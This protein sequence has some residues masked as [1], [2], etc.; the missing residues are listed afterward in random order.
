MAKM[1]MEQDRKMKEAE[2]KRFRM[3]SGFVILALVAV[4]AIVSLLLNRKNIIL[5]D[6]KIQEEV[7]AKELDLKKRE[8]TA[9]ALVQVERQGV[10]TEM[11]DKLKAIADDKSSLQNNVKEVI[12]T[13]EDYRNA[14]TPEDFEY[15]FTQTHP[16]FYNN[17]R[18][19]FPNLTSNEMRLCAFLKLNLTT[20]DIAAI[21]RISPE[22]AMVA[23]SRL[24]KKLNLVGSDEDLNRFLSKY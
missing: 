14:T 15:Y 16:D 19:D 18:A 17:L 5:K 12:K 6:K 23:R 13:F 2:S 21:C 10:L 11:I 20:K 1:E 9:N 24:R 22:S 4:I 8:M 7:M 3:V